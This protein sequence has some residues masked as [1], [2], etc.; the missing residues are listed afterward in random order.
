MTL[1]FENEKMPSDAW[2]RQ[3]NKEIHKAKEEFI[4]SGRIGGNPNGLPLN[5]KK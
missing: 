4:A 2:F 3:A 1:N 5:S